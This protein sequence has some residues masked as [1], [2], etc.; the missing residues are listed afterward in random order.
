MGRM[1]ATEMAALA[2][3]DTAL[4]WH[5]TSNHYPPLPIELVETAKVAITNGNAGDWDAEIELPE[6]ITYRDASTAPTW[7]AIQ[8]W[9]L[10]AFLD[11]EA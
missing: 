1:Q 4:R 11:E 8:A 7:A 6:G 3:I 2:D 5:L 10:D 9:H